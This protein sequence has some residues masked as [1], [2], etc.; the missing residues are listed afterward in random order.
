MLRFHGSRDKVSFE[1]V[2]HNSRLDELQAALLRLELPHLDAWCD[3]RRAA[4]RALRGRRPRRA[5][6]PARARRR[7]RSR[8]APLR[9]PPRAGRRRSAPR[10]PRPGSAASA[11]TACRCTASPRCA[12]GRD[13]E[14]PGH[15]RGRAHPPR[16]PDEP[17]AHPRAG[18]TRSSP[19]CAMRIWVDLTNSPARARHAPGDPGARAARGA[20]CDVTAR[21]FAQ[22]LGLL[23]ALRDRARGDRAPPR[24]PARRPRALGLASRSLALAAG[25]RGERF[26][27]ALGHGSN[28]VTVAA[29]AARRS[30]ARRRSTTSGRRSST[31]S[32]AGS[33]SGSSCR[34]RSRPSGS[35]R[36]GATAAKLRALPGAQGGVLPRG[37]RR[38]TP[39][40]WTSSGSTRPSR[41]PSCARRRRSRSTTASSTRCSRG[42]SSA[43]ASRRRSSCSRA[44]PSSAPSWRARAASSCPSARSTPSRWSRYAD[45]VV[46]AG[47]TMNREAV[48]LGTPVWTTFEGRLGAVDER[49]IAE[50]RLR[51]LERAEDVDRR[52]ARAARRRRRPRA[53]RSGG[54]RRPAGERPCTRSRRPFARV[55]CRGCAGG[56]DS[57][58]GLAVPPPQ[59]AAGGGR[60]RAGR[61]RLLPRLPA[62]LRR[63]G[64]RALR[65]TCSRA[66][67]AFV[68]VGSVFVFALFG[69]Y[70]HWMRY[71][72]PARLPADRAGVR[73]SPRSRCSPTSRSSSRG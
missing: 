23:R 18:R 70:R 21:D 48:A 22:T 44:R 11:T 25:P 54:L 33:R 27:V 39:P 5:R 17:G 50:G 38:P 29:E 60:R 68:V 16:D 69:L 20:R 1:L 72:T 30:R 51:R 15:R 45:L 56:S 28:D 62:A 12:R 13:V 34:T 66:R 63:R 14:L 43:C 3:G 31:P 37:L 4:R 9:G 32:T 41:S 49:L 52:Q 67:S 36:Y 7:L 10:S 57:A 53:A 40:S 46:S 2:G 42:C 59:P 64:P 6:R 24:R 71:A 35:R 58:A 55:E 65:R 61:A 26:D 73:S 19:P 8:L 47:G